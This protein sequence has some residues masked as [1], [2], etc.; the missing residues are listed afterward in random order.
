[1]NMPRVKI[2]GPIIRFG[3]T[4]PVCAP[5]RL[6]FVHSIPDIHIVIL[7]TILIIIVSPDEYFMSITRLVATRSTC[8][9]RAVGAILVKNRRILSTGYNGAPSGVA[10]CRD[11]GCVRMESKVPSGERAEI[12]RGLHAEQN[13]IIQAAFHGVSISSSTLY[14]TNLPCSIC[15]KMLINAGISEIVY[16][17]G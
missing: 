10:H 3:S 16:D 4:E 5:D 13:A 8:M 11:A 7:C 12:C 14:C 2:S 17:Y 9:R 1:M 15:V 6:S